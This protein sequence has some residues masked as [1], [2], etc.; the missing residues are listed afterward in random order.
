MISQ[1]CFTDHS[2]GSF[3]LN[4]NRLIEKSKL[5]LITNYTEINPL[6]LELSVNNIFLKLGFTKELFNFNKTKFLNTC[7]I[8]KSNYIVGLRHSNS[9]AAW[10]KTDV[11]QKCSVALKPRFLEFL[12]TGIVE[13]I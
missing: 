3:M 8:P 11:F 12:N 7:N 5:K 6:T 13:E 4:Y 9:S 2:I 10:R 1:T